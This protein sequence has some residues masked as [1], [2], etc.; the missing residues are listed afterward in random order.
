MLT[1]DVRCRI[2]AKVKA[3]ATEVIEAMG[4]NVS[5]AIRLFLKRVATEGTIPFDLRIPNAKTIAA[6]EEIENPK[7]RA[8]LKRYK[9]VAEMNKALA[10]S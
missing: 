8:K 9:S 3:E 2:D 1:T 6:M 10:R 5:D 7:K 4:L